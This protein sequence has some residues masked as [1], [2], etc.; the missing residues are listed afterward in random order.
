M[1]LAT[2]ILTGVRWNLS[3]T[4]IY[5]SIMTRVVEHFFMCFFFTHLDFF[6]WKSSAQFMCPFFIGSLIFG[7]FSYLNSLHILLLIPCQMYSWQRFCPILLAAS[8]I[9]WLCLLLCRVFLFH[10]IL[11]VNLFSELLNHW[12]AIWEV[13]A[14]ACNFQCIPFSFQN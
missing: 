2:V 5:I 8:S 4:L 1:F 14:F 6:L 11:F 13:I 10:S 9:R 7:K 3:E 12:I